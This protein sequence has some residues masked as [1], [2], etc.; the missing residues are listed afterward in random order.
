MDEKDR[1]RLLRIAH[2][3]G[4]PADTVDHLEQSV[5]EFTQARLMEKEVEP[6][7]E[8][9]F[10]DCWKEYR[11]R[12]EKY[13]HR[14]FVHTREEEIIPR[15]VEQGY[16]FN[17]VGKPQGLW[18]SCGDGWLSW[19]LGEEFGFGPNVHELTLDMSKMKT[20]ATEEEYDEFSDQYGITQG[21]YMARA[22]IAALEMEL[23]VA[24][25][26]EKKRALQEALE[27]KQTSFQKVAKLLFP[28]ISKED[29]EGLFGGSWMRKRFQ[30]YSI[31]WEKVE[32]D[33]FYG[34]E[35]NPYLW[36]RRLDGGMWYYG[37]DCASGVVWNEKAILD[38]R[39]VAY[40]DNTQD[41]I[42]ELHPVL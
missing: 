34:I 19:C 12:L 14:K 29:E 32:A 7:Q 5:T 24:T 42:V 11:D 10:N 28:G 8:Q 13:P 38:V 26:E 4:L 2:E 1:E 31:A 20:I 36:Q 6:E 23:K 21:E 37:W 18:Y 30:N 15:S 22:E 9:Q 39:L 16:R 40:Y 35:I 17:G 25:D 41:K 27:E 33:G 3:A